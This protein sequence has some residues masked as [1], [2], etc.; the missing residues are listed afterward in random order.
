MTEQVVVYMIPGCSTSDRAIR[1]LPEMGYEVLAK[2]VS[3]SEELWYELEDLSGVTPTIIW[4]DGRVE[5]GWK[6]EV[7]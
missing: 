5:V 6:G 4:P 1:E 2:D 7:G 3:S